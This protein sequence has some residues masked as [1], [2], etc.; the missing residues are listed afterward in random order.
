MTVRV[1]LISPALNAALR[2]A[3]FDGD[4][5]LDAAGAR[6]ARAAAPGV[7]DAGRRLH[8]PSVRCAGTAEALGLRA[9]PEPAVRGWDLGRW[10]GLRL[11]EVGAAEPAAVSAW[12]AD[13]SAAPHGGES[14]LELCSRTGRWLDSLGSSSGSGSGS[15]GRAGE[16]RVLAVVEPSVVRAA[17]VAALALPPESFWRLD[18][19]PLTLT[20]LSGRSGRWNLRCGQ[21]LSPAPAD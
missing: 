13:P 2:E 16:G 21:P 3:R 15:D 19:A 11:D 4:A 8:G 10:S 12:L 7:P 6:R 14:L 20:A 5:P 1:M 17:V 9:V 18:V